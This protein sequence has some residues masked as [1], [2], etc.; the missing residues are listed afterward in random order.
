MIPSFNG[1]PTPTA[2]TEENWCGMR[3]YAKIVHNK[4]NGSRRSLEPPRLPDPTTCVHRSGL[5]RI[6]YVSHPQ[7]VPSPTQLNSAVR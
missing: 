4:R 2:R 6:V 3:V 1:S 5:M 7:S